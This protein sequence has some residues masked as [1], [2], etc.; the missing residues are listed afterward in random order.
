MDAK[1]VT[2]L[3]ALA[4]LLIVLVAAATNVQVPVKPTGVTA[5]ATSDG[6]VR[7]SWNEDD[8]PVHRVGWAHDADARAANDAGDWL[9]AFHFADTRRD[10]DYVVKYLPPGQDY[11]FIV[12]AASARFTGATWSEWTSLTTACSG[13]DYDRD[14]WG[15]YPEADANATPRWTKST[16]DVASRDITQDHHVALKDAHIS[17]GCN[18]SSA[19][20]DEFSSDMENLNATTWSFN[21]SKANRTPDQ[22]TGIALRIIDTDAE[23]CD[24]ATQHEDVKEKYALSMTT[25]E[26][27]TVDNWLAM[28]EQNGG[29]QARKQS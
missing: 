28:C 5:T 6:H 10:T 25:A 13:D 18:W 23:R 11:W 22:L 20:K 26:Q 15:D 12:G 9:E 2:V 4:V 19:K 1:Y 27:T 21:S 3:V 29:N 7:V 16:D 17:G 14:E 8:A 24:Y